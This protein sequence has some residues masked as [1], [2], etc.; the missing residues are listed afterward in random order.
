M[1]T[2]TEIESAHAAGDAQTLK[3]VR[4]WWCQ[5]HSCHSDFMDW[6][7]QLADQGQTGFC[8]GRTEQPLIVD[9]KGHKHVND[10]HLCFRSSVRGVVMLEVN[11]MDL[12]IMARTCMHGLNERDPSRGFNLQWFTGQKNPDA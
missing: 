3:P 7:A 6:G 9:R 11:E 2:K 5:D 10:G 12:M 1:P 8:C 4:P